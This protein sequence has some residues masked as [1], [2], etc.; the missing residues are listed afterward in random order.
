M[1]GLIIIIFSISSF[2]FEYTISEKKVEFLH[3]GSK[4]VST[5]CKKICIALKK[6]VPAKITKGFN[7]T[8]GKN[9]ATQACKYVGG[10]IVLATSKLGH[11]TYF[12]KFEDNSF[13]HSGHLL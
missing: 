13:I 6:S 1:I 9:P 8:M 7:T 3:V 2:G 10:E 5:N 11:Q 4:L 12:C